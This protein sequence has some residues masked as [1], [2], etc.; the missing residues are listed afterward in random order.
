III[1]GVHGQPVQPG[2][3]NFR[4]AELVEREVQPEKHL[5]ADV[6]HIVGPGD[7]PR[8]RAQNTLPIRQNDFVEGSAIAFLRSLDQLEVNQH[9]IESWPASKERRFTEKWRTGK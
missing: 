8:D 7:Q 9:A 6:F 4:A 3:E 2:L 5:L 1:G